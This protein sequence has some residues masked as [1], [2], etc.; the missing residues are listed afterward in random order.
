MRCFVVA[1]GTHVFVFGSSA[2]HCQVMLV[3][4]TVLPRWPVT[5]NVTHPLL[6]LTSKTNEA[7][8]TSPRGLKGMNGQNGGSLNPTVTART[9]TGPGNGAGARRKRA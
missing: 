6:P 1:K 4:R 9:V 5:L 2:C 7:G 3:A 8:E